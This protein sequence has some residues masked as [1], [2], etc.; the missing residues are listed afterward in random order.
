MAKDTNGV[1]YDDMK[2]ECQS[3]RPRHDE[4]LF[5]FVKMPD[6]GVFAVGIWGTGEDA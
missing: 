1:E 3:T 4:R 2:V 5:G 6:G